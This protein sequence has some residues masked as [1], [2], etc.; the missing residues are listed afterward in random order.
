M[1]RFIKSLLLPSLFLSLAILIAGCSG[2]TGTGQSKGPPKDLPGP[3]FNAAKT[4]E[5]TEKYGKPKQG[6]EEADKEDKDKAA[7][8]DKAADKKKTEDKGKDDKSKKDK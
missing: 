2:D 4:K 5:M 1:V 3:A 6:A 7:E 8:K